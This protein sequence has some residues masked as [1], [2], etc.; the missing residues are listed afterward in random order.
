[1]N[2]VINHHPPAVFLGLG[3]GWVTGLVFM[4]DATNNINNM[5][6]VFVGGCG[7]C[8]GFVVA[9]LRPI[10]TSQLDLTVVHFWPIN[11]IIFGGP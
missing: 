9:S 1:M 5:N 8:W 11:P 10:S 6:G 3:V 7:V 2:P 4:V